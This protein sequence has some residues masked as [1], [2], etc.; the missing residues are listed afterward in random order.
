[1]LK[2]GFAKYDI[3]P[4]AGVSL[5]GFGPFLNRNA[6]GVRDYLEARAAALALGGKRAL[7]IGCD[8]CTLQAET[9]A[10]I[11]DIIIAQVPGLAKQDIM[12]STSHTHSGPATVFSDR[13][14][15]APDAPYMEILPYKIAQAGILAAQDLEPVTVSAALA[16]CRH[17]GLNRVYDRD[18]PPLAEVLQEGWEPARPDLTDT[19]CRVIRFDKRDGQMKGFMAYFGCHPV[20]C[21]Q[22]N[23]FIHGDYPGVAIHNLMREFP[24]TTGIFLQGAQGDV[25]SGCVHKKENESLLALDVFAARFANAIRKGLAA[26]T[27]LHI[28]QLASVSQSVDFSTRRDFSLE[29]LKELQ[30]EF[31]KVLHTPLA[32]DA[33]QE[34]RMATVYYLGVKKMI[35][36][37]ESGEA[38]VVTAEVQ[39]IRLGPLAYLGAP[40]EIM[41]AIKNETIAKLRSPMPM[42]MGLCNG[43]YGYAPDRQSLQEAIQSASSGGYA[44]AKVPLM[45]GRL[46]YANIHD[47]LVTAFTQIDAQLFPVGKD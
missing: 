32:D 26:A 35:A 20:V 14:W 33:A 30:A 21:C 38:P 18:A 2:A 27:P 42:V 16:P 29:H 23:H 31:A 40:F 1:M 22:D 47:E 9:C 11:R 8:L 17:I 43:A 34:V 19:E 10:Q 15:G 41:Q 6:V 46:P 36:Q 12:I 28:D 4:R 44:A 7:I 13:G 3:T 45:L 24:G 39:G 25:N 5:Y 37:L